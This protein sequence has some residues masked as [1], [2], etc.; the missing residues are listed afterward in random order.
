MYSESLAYRALR[1][2]YPAMSAN[3]AAHLARHDAPKIGLL[4]SLRPTMD[5]CFIGDNVLIPDPDSANGF[6]LFVE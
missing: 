2:R 1:L 4:A 6:A 3:M 5:A